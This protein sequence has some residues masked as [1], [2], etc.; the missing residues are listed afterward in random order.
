MKRTLYVNRENKNGRKN[1]ILY[2]ETIKCRDVSSVAL[3]RI[4]LM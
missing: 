1:K 2:Y 4:G 3:N